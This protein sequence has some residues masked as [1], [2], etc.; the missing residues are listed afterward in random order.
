[1]FLSKIYHWVRQSVLA[2]QSDFLHDLTLKLNYEPDKSFSPQELSKIETDAFLA[3]PK[4]IP[5]LIS[6]I[7]SNLR[8]Y[9]SKK[10][11]TLLHFLIRKLPLQATPPLYQK[12]ATYPLD[13]YLTPPK[14][15]A[16]TDER[17][18]FAFIKAY[19]KYLLS[20]TFHAKIYKEDANL[21]N[22]CQEEKVELLSQALFCLLG[23]I[24]G[25]SKLDSLSIDFE[26][27]DFE[28]VESNI[29]GL[30]LQDLYYFY[31]EFYGGLK[32]G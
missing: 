6:D 5:P 31:G 1:M 7:L 23:V 11:L 32:G 9:N 26:D 16:T 14:I 8:V 29:V 3:D 10:T 22:F 2:D 17:N 27:M 18:F 4:S 19:Y 12:M 15:F 28:C 24:E 20:L 25:L 13:P 21:S 30:C